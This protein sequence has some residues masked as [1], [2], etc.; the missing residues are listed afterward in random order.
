MQFKY[1]RYIK[2]HIRK[3]FERDQIYKRW[4]KNKLRKGQ[5]VS[6]SVVSGRNQGYSF[7]TVPDNFSFLRNTKE[8]LE[9]IEKLDSMLKQKV[10]TFVNLEN[11]NE[12]DNGSITVLLSKMT[13]FRLAKIDFNGNLPKNSSAKGL[14]LSSGFLAHLFSTKNE[15]LFD[16]STQNAYGKA[17]QIITKPGN[18]VIPNIAMS[19]CESSAKTI[20][21]DRMATKGLYRTLIELMHNTNNHAKPNELGGELWWL[22]AH[23]DKEAKK[24]SFVFLD[25]GVGIFESLKNKPES[26]PFHGI[27]IK[28]LE[29]IKY[30]TDADVL[31]SILKGALHKT[32]TNL[33]HRG[34]GLNGVYKVNKRRQIKKLH[35]ISN[36]VYAD[37]DGNV[38]KLL[39][40]NLRGTFLYWEIDEGG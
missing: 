37:V 33:N 4:K 8:V 35:I 30:G 11:V 3:L 25:F 6:K 27:Y 20:N 40:C 19:I 16:D 39:N 34:K 36:N 13:E 5:N 10:R 15:G 29:R 22:T 23:H 26:S 32:S 18:K 38:Y 2:R 1:K 12:I 21:K 7:V 28:I 17:N 9:V 31:K 14:L 24:V